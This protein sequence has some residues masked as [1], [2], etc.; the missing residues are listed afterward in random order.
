MGSEVRFEVDVTRAGEH[1]GITLFL[2]EEGDSPEDS[3]EQDCYFL[4][5]EGEGDPDEVA[6]QFGVCHEEAMASVNLRGQVTEE[7][8]AALLEDSIELAGELMVRHGHKPMDPDDV[9]EDLMTA[10]F[11]D[12]EA[13]VSEETNPSL[14]N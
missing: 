12:D 7:L 6:R 11:F 14:L 9:S 3:S 4:V 2:F 10:L 5:F 13:P 1:L 8:F